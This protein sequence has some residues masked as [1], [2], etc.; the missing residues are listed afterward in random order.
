MKKLFLFLFVSCFA[1]MNS[2]GDEIILQLKLEG[3]NPEQDGG[4]SPSEL[5][6]ASLEN[7]SL[8]LFFT[9]S[10]SSQVVITD[11][12]TNTVVYSAAFGVASTQVISLSS[13]PAGEYELSIYA[14]GT[15]WE[16]EFE[17]E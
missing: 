8:T 5:V 9:P 4:K 2:F 7:N 10:A 14:Y 15:W 16:G 13:F 17:I 6:T 3:G 1:C 12:Q 11:S